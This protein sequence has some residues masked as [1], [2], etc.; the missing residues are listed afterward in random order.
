MVSYF[1]KKLLVKEVYLQQSTEEKQFCFVGFPNR[2]LSI[3][4]FTIPITILQ[5]YY[6]F[7]GF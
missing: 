2:L 7:L 5:W 6:V 1:A 4:L 3:I